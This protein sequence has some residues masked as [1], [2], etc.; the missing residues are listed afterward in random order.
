MSYT[1]LMRHQNVV[2]DCQRVSCNRGP[3]SALSGRCVISRDIVLGCRMEMSDPD[4]PYMLEPTWSVYLRSQAKDGQ[5]LAPFVRRVSFRMSPKL[6]LRLHVADAAPFEISEVLGTDF[7]LEVQ[8]QYMDPRM[9]ATTYVFRP[10]A[11]REGHSGMCEEMHDKMIF[12]NPSPAMR[13]SLAP[14]QGPGVGQ[15]APKAL[16]SASPLASATA[17]ATSS[18]DQALKER[19]GKAVCEEVGDAPHRSEPQLNRDRER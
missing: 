2:D 11:V 9:T 15:A 17:S 12:V 1:H 10:R 5:D 13:L 8:V 6:P 7:P 4:M 18:P 3:G 16:A 14:A 19:K